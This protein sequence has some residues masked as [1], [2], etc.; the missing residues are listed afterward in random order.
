MPSALAL[1]NSN[2][3]ATRNVTVVLIAE[4]IVVTLGNVIQHQST[5]TVMI[6]MSVEWLKTPVKSQ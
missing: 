6:D 5:P 2:G 3:I 4:P 1:E